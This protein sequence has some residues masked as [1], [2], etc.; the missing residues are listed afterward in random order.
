MNQIKLLTS[1]L[2]AGLLAEILTGCPGGATSAS[3]TTAATSQTDTGTSLTSATTAP[4]SATTAQT[5]ATS[6]SL[7]TTTTTPASVRKPAIYL[8]PSQATAVRVT[9]TFQG[10]L[11]CTYPTYDHG[12]QITAYP[13]GR[14]VNQADG[15]EYSY[16]Y[17]EGLSAASYDFSQGFVVPGGQTTAFLQEK[18]AWLGLTPRE[19]N[20]FIV[21]WLPQMQG[22]PYNLITFQD[23]A[24]T[25]QAALAIEPQPDSLLRIFMAY[26]PLQ[27]PVDLPE[28]SL[29][30]FRRTGFA[31]VEWGGTCV[32]PAT[33]P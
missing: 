7:T 13:D 25:D 11:T 31:V 20:E 29:R 1:L 32:E 8:Y 9:L 30:R 24:Y 18:L 17:W 28:P 14:L 33:G 10:L 3:Q 19:Y 21:Y 5:T 2:L 27:E 12:W 6:Q 4:S 22:N 26:R 15:R 16:L 23:T